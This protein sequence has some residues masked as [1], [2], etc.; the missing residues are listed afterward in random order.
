[1]LRPMADLK[2]M[3][4]L[5]T[6]R[7]SHLLGNGKR[8]TRTFKLRM[9]TRFTVWDAASYVLPSRKRAEWELH[10]RIL[11]LQTRPLTTQASALENFSHMGSSG[12]E[13]PNTGL[14][15]VALPVKLQSLISSI[16][17]D[18]AGFE[19]AKDLP[20]VLETNPFVHSGTDLHI[21][22]LGGSCTHELRF[23]KPSP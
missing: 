5:L 8:R 10:P 1:M 22:G 2:R 18:R 20:L 3:F 9:E 11:V 12:L 4:L 15:P 14:Q 7:I 6:C 19:P 23:C 17:T 13:P 21:R 16:A